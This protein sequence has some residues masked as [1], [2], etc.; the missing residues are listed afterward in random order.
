MAGDWIDL[1]PGERMVLASHPHWW[2]YWK[3]VFGSLG[4]VLVF[5]LSLVTDGAFSTLLR[6]LAVAGAVVWALDMVYQFAQWRT[7]RFAVTDQRV[8]YQ[9]GLFRRRGVSIPLQRVNNVNFEQSF[10]ARLLDNG[11]VTIESAGQG[12]SVFENIPKP[13]DVRR[14]IFEQMDASTQSEADRTAA[15]VAQ[16][17]RPAAPEPAAPSTVS[18]RLAQLEDLR[19]KGV[20]TDAEYE[21]KRAEILDSL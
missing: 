19:A 12:D 8:A 17:M 14:I 20:V 6:W 1:M 16:A 21:A 13:A 10:V 5:V 18:D 11:V 7:T 4:V 2:F 3:E 15:A 9:S